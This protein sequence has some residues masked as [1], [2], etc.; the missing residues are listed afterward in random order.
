MMVELNLLVG[1]KI[2]EVCLLYN[3]K[4]PALRILKKNL[5]ILKTQTKK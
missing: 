2:I 4:G 1:Q 5:K 3:I